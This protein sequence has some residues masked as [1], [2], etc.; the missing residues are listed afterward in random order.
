[1]PR[2]V[3]DQLKAES[4]EVR[5]YRGDGA[6]KEIDAELSVTA[7]VESPTDLTDRPRTIP[8]RVSHEVTTDA[9]SD[10]SQLASS[11]Q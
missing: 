2:E 3:I 8:R 4:F 1:M 5:C 6:E 7:R 11:G 10:I 9:I